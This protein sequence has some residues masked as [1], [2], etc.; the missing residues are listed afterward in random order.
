MDRVK[1]SE[2]M[3]ECKEIYLC[4]LESYRRSCWLLLCLRY[5]TFTK[6]LGTFKNMW[7]LTWGIFPFLGPLDLEKT[8]FSTVTL[9][10]MS[11]NWVVEYQ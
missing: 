1:H 3:A 2:Q 9:N 10:A 4:L 6:A 8:D 7:F 5:V 11:D